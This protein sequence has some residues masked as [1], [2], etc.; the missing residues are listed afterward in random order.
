MSR[1]TVEQRRAV[2][3]FADLGDRLTA[4]VGM[5]RADLLDGRSA[6]EQ[7]GIAYPGFGSAC[8]EIANADWPAKLWITHD[9]CVFS[10]EPEWYS[11]AGE[12]QECPED[13]TYLNRSAVKRAVL[14]ELAGYL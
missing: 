9:A 10:I 1:L 7:D 6:V 12:P 5:A 8:R 11:E 13:Y 2:R 14:G 4:L 3:E